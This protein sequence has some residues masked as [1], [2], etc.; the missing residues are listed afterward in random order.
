MTRD[1]TLLAELELFLDILERRIVQNFEACGNHGQ[2]ETECGAEDLEKR[3]GFHDGRPFARS[4]PQ[5]LSEDVATLVLKHPTFVDPAPAS[6]GFRFYS[7]SESASML[8]ER[9][10]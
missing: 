2:G 5:S 8:L 7:V 4:L 9:A 1:S 3:R 6:G 10:H